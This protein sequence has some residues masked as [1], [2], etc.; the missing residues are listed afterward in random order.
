MPPVGSGDVHVSPGKHV[1]HL[2]D[3]VPDDRRRAR[4]LVA[5]DGT[6]QLTGG[7]A[8]VPRR[9]DLVEDHHL[10]TR[11]AHAVTKLGLGPAACWAH[12]FRLCPQSVYK[13]NKFFTLNDDGG[14][15]AFRAGHWRARLQQ[16]AD[17][18]GGGN[19]DG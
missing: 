14:V 10:D 3:V 13:V 5:V 2:M 6:Q 15:F 7:D 18:I 17:E 12:H 19:H 4:H 8:D 16:S 11:Q 9:L 1:V